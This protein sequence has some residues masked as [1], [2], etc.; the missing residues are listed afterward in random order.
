VDR[1]NILMVDN[2]PRKLLTYEVVLEEL[3]EN[4]VK[5]HSGDEALNYLLKTEIAIVLLDVNMPGLDGFQLADVIR[6]HPRYQGIAV[7]FISAS[8]L[9]DADH[10]EG[11]EHGAVDYISVPIIPGLLR[12]K[13]RVFADLYRKTR[14]LERLN[15]ELRKI[16]SRMIAIQD[17]ERR[18]I[19]R[20][21][22]D[23]LG[24]HLTLAKMTADGI[25]VPEARR[26]AEDVGQMIAEALCQVRTISH[27]LHPPLLDEIGLEFA[28]RWLLEG[29]MK[30]SGIETMMDLEPCK[31]PRLPEDIENALYRI[32]QEAVTNSV[33]HSGARKICVVLKKY[34]AEVSLAV[35]DDGKGI[36][37]EISTFRSDCVGV[38]VQGMRQRVRELGGEIRLW[39]SNPGT[40]VEIV[41]PIHWAQ[42]DIPGGRE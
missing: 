33:R 39:N 12:A 6:Q 40:H 9:T 2:D 8:R 32:T 23:S 38:G 16:S 5:A 15:E 3:G 11:Y 28:I 36:P 21:L 4:L 31:F 42:S 30:R 1:I 7:I 25:K 20:E 37:E 35:C 24:Q 26:Q 13:V 19:A 17:E 29:L 10:L 18:R 41:I 14:Q 27:L 22:H 34:D